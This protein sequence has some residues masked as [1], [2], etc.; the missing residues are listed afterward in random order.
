LKGRK[1]KVPID[2]APGSNPCRVQVEV[3]GSGK[4]NGKKGR[5][6][7][8]HKKKKAA[9]VLGRATVTIPG[10]QS[11][12]VA[13]KLS[14]RGRSAVSRRRGVRIKVTT[15]DPAGDTVQISSLNSGGKKKHKKQ[16]KH[17]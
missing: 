9:N 17:S 14:R 6:A 13:I 4:G 10:G 5:S 3:T 1:L 2:S 16:K 11:Q 12:T 8:K 7:K 15:V